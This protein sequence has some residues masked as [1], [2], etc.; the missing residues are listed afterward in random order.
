MPVSESVDRLRTFL[1]QEFKIL[2]QD[3]SHRVVFVDILIS[4]PYMSTSSTLKG[5]AERSNLETM[6][7]P[8]LSIKKRISF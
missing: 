4:E 7:M 2:R 8:V 3:L 6:S 5:L 1:L